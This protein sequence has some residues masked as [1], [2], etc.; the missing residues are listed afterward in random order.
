MRK[1]AI[2]NSDTTKEAI[3]HAARRRFA[4]LGFQQATIRTIAS[5][6]GID[7]AMVIRYFGTK[8]GLFA[9]A[10][11]FD[12]RIPD[13]SDVPRR[14]QGRRLVEH[15]LDRWE[16]DSTFIALLRSAVT[17]QVARDRLFDVFENQVVGFIGQFTDDDSATVRA[18]LIASQLFGT[19]LCRY[20][21]ELPPVVDMPREELV[22]WLGGTLQRYLTK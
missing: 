13:L 18:G 19:A 10:A 16:A 17:H 2:R 7:P 11:D 6:A 3:K 22:G 12:L 21:L 15:F 14:S 4:E 9:A 8:E 1:A 5:D 20:V